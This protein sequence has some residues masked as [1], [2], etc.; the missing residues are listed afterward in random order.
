MC[1]PS[2][3]T[4]LHIPHTERLTYLARVA[5]IAFVSLGLHS[6]RNHARVNLQGTFQLET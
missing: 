3:P 6:T 5:I 4:G 1:S 2:A